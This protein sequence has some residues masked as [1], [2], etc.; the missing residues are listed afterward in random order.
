MK[1]KRTLTVAEMDTIRRATL[2]TLERAF[3][4]DQLGMGGM[5]HSPIAVIVIAADNAAEVASFMRQAAHMA[6]GPP[7]ETIIYPEE[8]REDPKPGDRRN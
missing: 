4:P 7:S 6:F 1:T 8:V 3:Q 5:V 2:D